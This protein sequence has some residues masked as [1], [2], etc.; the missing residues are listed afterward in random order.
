[1]EEEAA[2]ATEC[3][4]LPVNTSMP[5][6]GMCRGGVRRNPGQGVVSVASEA[7]GMERDEEGAELRW[8][9]R[10]CPQLLNRSLFCQGGG[11]ATERPNLFLLHLL[12]DA[13]HCGTWNMSVVS[14]GLRLQGNERI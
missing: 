7:S 2:K 10:L 8:G 11:V 14:L 3:L 4:A 9:L 12:A 1:M 5:W 6:R 13:S